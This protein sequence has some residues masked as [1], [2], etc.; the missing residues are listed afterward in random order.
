MKKKKS[1]KIWDKVKTIIVIGLNYAQRK[2]LKI[3]ELKNIANISVYAKN[4]DYHEVIS[5]N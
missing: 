3:N 1:K 2:P 4:R 5:K